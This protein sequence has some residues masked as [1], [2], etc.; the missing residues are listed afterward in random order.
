MKKSI[1]N[2]RDRTNGCLRR[3][4]GRVSPDRRIAVIV[5]AFSLFAIVNIWIAASAIWSIGRDESRFE[6]TL[7]DSYIPPTGAPAEVDSLG[8][9]LREFLNDNFNTGEE[10]K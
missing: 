8:L 2:L 10:E 5:A 4:C 7:P 1:E 6:R 9:E 3:M